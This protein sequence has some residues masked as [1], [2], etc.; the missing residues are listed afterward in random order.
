MNKL[1]DIINLTMSFQPGFS[2]KLK[3]PTTLSNDGGFTPKDGTVELLN[4][5]SRKLKRGF[6]VQSEDVG[7][8]G[9]EGEYS[10]EVAI[11]YKHL[12][13]VTI[14]IWFYAYT[15]ERVRI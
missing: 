1:A 15:G 14:I 12:L 6:C 13:A 10:G 5:E 3:V 8:L 4:G 11:R 2:Y 7:T 9:D